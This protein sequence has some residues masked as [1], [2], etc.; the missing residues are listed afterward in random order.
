[1]TANFSPCE[2]AAGE[3][4]SSML[5]AARYWAQAQDWIENSARTSQEVMQSVLTIHWLLHMHISIIN[6]IIKITP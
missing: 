1:M 4:H 5:N 2:E 6:C 3:Q